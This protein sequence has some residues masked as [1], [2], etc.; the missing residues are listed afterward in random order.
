M[1]S[2]SRKRIQSGC[3]VSEY[4]VLHMSTKACKAQQRRSA[5][6]RRK[7]LLKL[8][9]ISLNG[10]R[11]MVRDDIMNNKFSYFSGGVEIPVDEE[12]EI[13]Y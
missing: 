10:S 2:S 13:V 7:Q 5:K 9:S 8:P 3:I 1:K 6:K 12:T 11:P 4:D